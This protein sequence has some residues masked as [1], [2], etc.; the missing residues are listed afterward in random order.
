MHRLRTRRGHGAYRGSLPR[1]MTTRE[2]PTSVQGRLL[3]LWPGHAH[4]GVAGPAIG[5]QGGLSAHG[6]KVVRTFRFMPKYMP[7]DARAVLDAA[8]DMRAAGVTPRFYQIS[9]AVEALAM[10]KARKRPLVQ[11]P[12]GCGKS[13]V[14]VLLASAMARLDRR[15]QLAVADRAELIGRRPWANDPGAALIKHFAQAGFDTH[16]EKAEHWA[17]PWA[18]RMDATYG[19]TPLVVVGSVQTM[20]GKRRKKWAANEWSLQHV[21]ECHHGPADTWS[22]LINAW[23]DTVGVVG[24][25]ATPER[26]GMADLFDLVHYCHE[27]NTPPQPGMTLQQ[28]QDAGWLVPHRSRVVQIPGWDLT[29]LRQKTVN[30]G[31]LEKALTAS[32]LEANAENALAPIVRTLR[33]LLAE[34]KALVFAPGV[35][36]AHKIAGWLAAHLEPED[37]AR[38]HRSLVQAGF[39]EEAV[40]ATVATFGR[41][42]QTGCITGKTP[43]A[44][45]DLTMRRFDR[46]APGN[47]GIQVMVGVGVFDEGVD[48]KDVHVAALVCGTTSQRRYFQRVGRVLRPASE[49]AGQLGDLPTAHERRALIAASSKPEALVLHFAG[50]QAARHA[51]KFVT[52]AR[53][54]H[55]EYP[56]LD[57]EEL[58]DA[59]ESG[60]PL[61]MDEL[62]AKHDEARDAR[63]KAAEEARAAFEAREKRRNA[64][65]ARLVAQPAA[66]DV[67]ELRVSAKAA[68]AARDARAVQVHEH[69][70]SVRKEDW[71]GAW[72]VQVPDSDWSRWTGAKRLPAEPVLRSP[73]KADEFAS[74]CAELRDTMI[75]GLVKLRVERPVAERI[76]TAAQVLAEA[77]TAQGVR[78]E[79]YF[80]AKK[81]DPSF[82]TPFEK[83]KQ[84]QR[85]RR[86]KR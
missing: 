21:D 46:W 34:C 40:S 59:E 12:T 85:F 20:Q 35:A 36:S 26:A 78:N 23:D 55:A 58:L 18:L 8:A 17:R 30:D 80:W 72:R 83:H 4:S 57:L 28:A 67:E 77:W 11:M 31:A 22:G 37:V 63:A 3:P 10:L 44:E 32:E 79:I 81:A 52:P 7:Y 19:D 68:K 6:A 41:A 70:Q 51:I 42:L 1:G 71:Q 86:S 61:S 29:H 16:L 2:R 69:A 38:Q 66:Y 73:K 27:P 39:A 48:V 24:Y 65:R 47:D 53:L 76:A 5:D 60:T 56:E 62:R 75:A 14:M 54:L 64:D 50:H 84:K 13:V 82:Q 43:P 15:P 49:I 45:R 9:A 33:L 25:S 74:A